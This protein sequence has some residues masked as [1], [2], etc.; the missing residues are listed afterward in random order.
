M[1]FFLLHLFNQAFFRACIIFFILLPCYIFILILPHL[2]SPVCP[3][4]GAGPL[5]PGGGGNAARVLQL[6]QGG[7]G[8][9]ALLEETNLQNYRPLRRAHSRLLQVARLPS[10]AGVGLCVKWQLM[11]CCLKAAVFCCCL[12]RAQN[13]AKETISIIECVC[14]Y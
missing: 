11:F 6:D 8:R 5:L 7:P 2:V 12:C 4:S 1:H 13:I 3:I 9:R 10:A 14:I